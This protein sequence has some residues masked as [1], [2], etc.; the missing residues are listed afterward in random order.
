MWYYI[1]GAIL[2]CFLG[3]GIG[4]CVAIDAKRNPFEYGNPFMKG[5][6][7]A[8]IWPLFLLYIGFIWLVL[9]VDDRLGG[10]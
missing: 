9:L 3:I 4:I 7:V 10:D 1:T 6:L 5:L 8:T 2:Y